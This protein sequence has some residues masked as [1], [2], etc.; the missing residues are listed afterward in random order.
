MN[1]EVII[2]QEFC[3]PLANMLMGQR[4]FNLS[5]SFS[6]VP[7]VLTASAVT[8]AP[9]SLVRRRSERGKSVSKRLLNTLAVV[10]HFKAQNIGSCLNRVVAL[11][12]PECRIHWTATL[13]DLILNTTKCQAIRKSAI[14]CSFVG[15]VRVFPVSRLAAA[16]QKGV[17]RLHDLS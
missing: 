6:F 4:G 16:N 10:N 7:P 14:T 1:Q 11:V 15:K 9:R 12:A 8:S 13:Y 17:M 2:G 3:W 5:F